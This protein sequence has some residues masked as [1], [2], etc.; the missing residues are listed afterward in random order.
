MRY[1]VRVFTQDGGFVDTY[2]SGGS[3]GMAASAAASRFEH[4]FGMEACRA[5]TFP[6]TSGGAALGQ[7]CKRRDAR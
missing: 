7:N 4:F 2:A 3:R 1:R 6:T 5:E